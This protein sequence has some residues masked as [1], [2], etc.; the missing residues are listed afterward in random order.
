[1]WVCV[2]VS[3]HI[4]STLRRRECSTRVDQVVSVLLTSGLIGHG[5]TLVLEREMF[6]QTLHLAGVGCKLQTPERRLVSVKISRRQTMRLQSSPNK[7]ACIRLHRWHLSLLAESHT[8][9]PLGP[10]IP[11]P[12]HPSRRVVVAQPCHFFQTLTLTLDSP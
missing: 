2:C 8:H 4:V 7:H 5:S 9:M 11:A 6:L 10:T 1:M 3:H 12:N